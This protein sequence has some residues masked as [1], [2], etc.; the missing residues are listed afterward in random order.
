[1]NGGAPDRDQAVRAW[2]E[3]EWNAPSV[4]QRRRELPP[5]DEDLW[6]ALGVTG[7]DGWEFIEEFGEAFG[8]D[9]TP[10][11]WYFHG[12]EEGWNLGAVLSRPPNR[13]VERI[14]I[15]LRLLGEAVQN[16]RWPVAYPPHR[17]PAV[18][19][20]MIFNQA[21]F[22]GFALLCFAALIAASIG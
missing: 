7:D 8:V 17:L 13:R 21:I 12:E 20:D 6:L 18:R 22:V 11:L 1:M 9:M 10:F 2:V 14:P 19:S 4:F 5:E 3:R 16:G 15:T